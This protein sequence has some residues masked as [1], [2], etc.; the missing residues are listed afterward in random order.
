[1]SPHQLFG[2]QANITFTVKKKE[3]ARKHKK[4]TYQSLLDGSHEVGPGLLGP[5]LLLLSL[6]LLGEGFVQV[7]HDEVSPE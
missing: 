1:M 4:Q 5:A 7:R 3:N 6:P 2:F